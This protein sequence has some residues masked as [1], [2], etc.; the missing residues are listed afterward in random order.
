MRLNDGQVRREG[1]LDDITP[2]FFSIILSVPSTLSSLKG[3]SVFQK[4]ES[5]KKMYSIYFEWIYFC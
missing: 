2:E 4:N 5:M 3:H 1:I